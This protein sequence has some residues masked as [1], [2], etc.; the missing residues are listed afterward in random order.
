[1]KRNQ[2]P[3]WWPPLGPGRQVAESSVIGGVGRGAY[4]AIIVLYLTT[5]RDFSADLVAFALTLAGIFGVVAGIPIGRLSDSIGHGRVYVLCTLSEGLA[6]LVLGLTSQSAITIACICAAATAERGGSAARGGVIAG[7]SGGVDRSVLRGQ[8]HSLGAVG[9]VVGATL[10]GLAIAHQSAS[11]YALALVT[12]AITIIISG[13]IMGRM[14]SLTPARAGASVE[15]TQPIATSYLVLTFLRGIIFIHRGIFTVGLPLWIVS[16]TT[17][18]QWTAAL[19]IGLSTVAVFLGQVRVSSTMVSIATASKANQKSSIG[20]FA[21]C[22]LYSLT[23]NNSLAVAAGLLLVGAVIHI[24]SALLR[25]ASAFYLGFELAPENAQ[26]QYQRAYSTGMAL[27]LMVAP[28]VIVIFV[29]NAGLLG[30]IALGGVIA[31]A[32]LL[33]SRV[34]ALAERDLRTRNTASPAG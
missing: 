4:A 33:S 28:A 7:I 19:V 16:H 23:S 3:L 18:P 34:I 24:F 9:L 6:I 15:G 1:M 22:C 26:G 2:Q 30:W 14:R 5:V 31:V 11:A 8:L 17:L 20:L 10:S 25:N 21:A 27:S 13:L 12:V 32:G 29:M